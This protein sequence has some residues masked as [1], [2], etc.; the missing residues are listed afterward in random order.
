MALA[1]QLIRSAPK[2]SVS[3]LVKVVA[4]WKDEQVSNLGSGMQTLALVP[5][6]I[7]TQLQVSVN[8]ARA[9]G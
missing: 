9:R 5:R 7:E 2:L 3:G 6:D 4:A 8:A 1:T